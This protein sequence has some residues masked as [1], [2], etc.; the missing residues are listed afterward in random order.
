MSHKH[1][2]SWSMVVQYCIGD[3]WTLN[4]I[5]MLS[6]LSVPTNTVWNLCIPS[7]LISTVSAMTI[8][9]EMAEERK[10]ANYMDPECV[11]E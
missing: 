11:G 9:R 10:I 8:F 6:V 1:L 5:V 7:K 2:G 4:E 3:V